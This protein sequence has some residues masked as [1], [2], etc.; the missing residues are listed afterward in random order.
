[1]KDWFIMKVVLVQGGKG[2]KVQSQKY[3][4]CSYFGEKLAVGVG[5]RQCSK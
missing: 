2:N 1:M 3:E 4:D 5:V